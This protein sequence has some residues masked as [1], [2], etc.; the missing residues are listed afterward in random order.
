MQIMKKPQQLKQLNF[1][2]DKDADLWV[3]SHFKFTNQYAERSKLQ[4]FI[5]HGT[6]P[7]IRYGKCLLF[8][9]VKPP[10]WDGP[11]RGVTFTLNENVIGYVCGWPSTENSRQIAVVVQKGNQR[12]V[13]ANG[14]NGGNAA[15]IKATDADIRPTISFQ[16]LSR[17]YDGYPDTIFKKLS[18]GEITV[19]TFQP[20]QSLPY[21]ASKAKAKSKSKRK[22][23]KPPKPGFVR[24]GNKWHRSATVILYDLKTKKCFLMGQDGRA[25]FGCEL[26]KVVETI[27]DAYD[28]LMPDEVQSRSDYQRQGEWFAIP[29][30]KKDVPD[31]KDCIACFND[32]TW[33]PR[34]DP[35]GSR[36]YLRC[37]EG[38]IGR[39]GNIYCYNLSMEHENGDH[40]DL[41]MK[42]WC[43]L[44]RN[45]AIRSFSEQGVD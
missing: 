42:G 9:G 28:A 20:D 45:H 31:E 34:D 26:P 5:R 16:C 18:K 13:L 10:N 32:S 1:A 37:H 40:D 22:L 38:R 4:E 27:E 39:D 11:R 30:D 25:Y 6:P 41:C 15:L 21:K 24:V 35:Q 7:L 14:D 36:H 8:H 44:R 43:Y 29:V 17:F 23:P 33:P 19:V 2:N 12:L 3:N